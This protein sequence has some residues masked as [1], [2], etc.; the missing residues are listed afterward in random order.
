MYLLNRF[1][2]LNLLFKKVASSEKGRALAIQ[3]LLSVWTQNGPP[4]NGFQ[5]SKSR[6]GSLT[7][8]ETLENSRMEIQWCV[9][10]RSR[11]PIGPNIST[12]I[13]QAAVLFISKKKIYKMTT[14]REKISKSNLREAGQG[15]RRRAE[16]SYHRPHLFHVW[17]CFTRSQFSYTNVFVWKER[18]Q[19]CL[20]SFLCWQHLIFH[21]VTNV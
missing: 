6:K 2:W 11:V 1:K 14:N 7:I 17:T 16:Y 9:G 8:L 12:S 13:W 3:V 20:R 4:L 15:H 18:W 21:S 10:V 5:A 19:S